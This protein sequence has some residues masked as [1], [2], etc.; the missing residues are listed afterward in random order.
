MRVKVLAQLPANATYGD[1]PSAV[2]VG[3][4]ILMGRYHGDAVAYRQ[5]PR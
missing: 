5:A 1:D 3:D 4:M 2:Q